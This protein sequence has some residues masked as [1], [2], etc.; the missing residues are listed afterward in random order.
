MYEGA[1]SAPRS[2]RV[3]SF[4]TGGPKGV[5][6]QNGPNHAAFPSLVLRRSCSG[7]GGSSA[8]EVGRLMTI[9]PLYP[10]GKPCSRG[11]HNE[12]VK[13]LALFSSIING[14]MKKSRLRI[15]S[16]G[17][18]FYSPIKS[19]ISSHLHLNTSNSQISQ[20]GGIATFGPE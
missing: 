3:K 10:C 17:S 14:I 1:E 12:T 6:K 5:P 4:Q 18:V 7:V 19:K 9:S 13:N 2:D 15:P 11:T 8:W 16:R 20:A